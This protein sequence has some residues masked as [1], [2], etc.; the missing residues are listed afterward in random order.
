MTRN[1]FLFLLVLVLIFHT[2]LLNAQQ[3]QKN[4]FLDLSGQFFQLKDQKNYGLI[5]YGGNIYVGYSFKQAKEK[6]ILEYDGGIG[7]GA[8]ASK[9]I[10]GI[11]LFLK[12]VDISACYRISRGE[13]HRF[14]LGPYIAMN[15]YFQL[16][17]EL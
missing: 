12:P 7:I 4:S 5:Y 8:G 17:P 15:Y 2:H 6:R 16:Y 10:A 3:K 9:E 14:Y 1:I 11:N 13:R